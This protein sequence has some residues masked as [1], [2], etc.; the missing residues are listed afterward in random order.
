MAVAEGLI[1]I[2]KLLVEAGA[3]LSI[4]T[5]DFQYTALDFAVEGNHKECG[6]YL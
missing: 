5:Y 3:N 1:E 6:E 4:E 2:V